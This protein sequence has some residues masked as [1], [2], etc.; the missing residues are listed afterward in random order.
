MAIIIDFNNAPPSAG[1]GRFDRVPQGTYMVRPTKMEEAQTSNDNP[2][3][4][5]TIS[6]T[7]GPHKGKKVR[8]QFVLPRNKSDAQFGAMR[9]H[10]LMVACGLKRQ[11]KKVAAKKVI[12]SLLKKGEAVAEIVDEDWTTNDGATRTSSKVASYY[13]PGSKEG[14]ALLKDSTSSKKS[15]KAKAK[16]KDEEDDEDEDED[17]DEDS[18]DSEDDDEDSDDDSDDE[19]IDEL[20]DD[21]EDEDDEDEDED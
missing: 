7:R 21:D 13:A 19:D 14:K 3:I 17:E 15:K 16:A 2:S 18:D 9:L 12:Q 4:I 8:E 1:G 20:L 11:D 5:A 10:G 6:I